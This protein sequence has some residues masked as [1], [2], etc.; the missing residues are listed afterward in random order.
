LKRSQKKKEGEGRRKRGLH[1]LSFP[2]TKKRHLMELSK[3]SQ[4]HS[5]G[6][7]EEFPESDFN[8]VGAKDRIQ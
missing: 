6:R 8:Y 5:D 1:T 3:A 4:W 2:A 7:K